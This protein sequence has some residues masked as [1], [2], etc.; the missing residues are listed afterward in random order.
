[1]KPYVFLLLLV[2]ACHARSVQDP[3]ARHD[4]RQC[5]TYL[6]PRFADSATSYLESGCKTSFKDFLKKNPPLP[7]TTQHTPTSSKTPTHKG[8]S[9][10]HSK[11][12]GQL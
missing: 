6:C 1:M 8:P 4:A 2:G 9:G 12:G 7:Q 3:V 11:Q 5:G 10:G